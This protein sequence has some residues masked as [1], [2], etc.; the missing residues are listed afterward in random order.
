MITFLIVIL[1]IFFALGSV[2]PLFITDD[3]RDVV[4]V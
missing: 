2:V 4:A 3:I 1:T